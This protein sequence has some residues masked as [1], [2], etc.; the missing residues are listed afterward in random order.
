MIVSNPEFE[1]DRPVNAG[2][3]YNFLLNYKF[4]K[5]L[6]M[7]PFPVKGL[8]VLDVCC[9]SGMFSEYLAKKQAIVTGVDL[10][11]EA[12]E[13]AHIRKKKHGFE[14]YF[15]VA[16]AT[17]LPFPDDTFD[18]VFVHDGLHHL[19]EPYKAVGQM[20]RSAKKGIVI[21]EPARALITRISVALGISKDYEGKDHIYRF[22]ESEVRR[23]L[24]ELGISQ[25]TTNRYIMYYPHYPR[26]WFRLFGLPFLF[27][28]VKV[29][30]AAANVLFDWVGNKITF[31]AVKES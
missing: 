4:E 21:I 13:R 17:N 1:V 10:S 18:V 7:L 26:W 24:Q 12:I 14:A 31:V 2:R 6:K 30:F 27:E 22:E 19:T 16:D 28:A 11:Q 20:V 23:W 9:G 8:S 15:M 5:A 29:C 3:L 25:I